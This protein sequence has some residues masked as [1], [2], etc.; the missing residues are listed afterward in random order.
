MGNKREKPPLPPIIER[1]LV[2]LASVRGMAVR[3]LE[4]YRLDLGRFAGYCQN[5]GILAEEATRQEVRCFM[6]DISAEDKA[7]VTVNRSLAS[8]RGFYR[9]LVRFGYR[10]DNPTE[11]I[12]SLKTPKI[13]PVFLWVEEMAAFAA[14][15]DQAQILWPV[16]DKAL[17]LTLYSGG[18]RISEAASMKMGRLAADLSG[19]RIIG[20]GDKERYVFFSGEAVQ[21]LKA[22]L[23]VRE[24]KLPQENLNDWLFLN[25]KGGGLSVSGVR[26][27]IY[28]YALRSGLQKRLHPHALRHSFAAHLVNAGCD[29]RVVQALLGHESIATTQRYTHVNMERLKAVYAQAH[30]HGRK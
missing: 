14:L 5:R 8:L 13:L 23:P 20:K 17:L 24:E 16:R 9:W 2:Y 11:L 7:V 1:Y 18:L 4:A 22:Y 12:S 26:W 19:A 29:V 6:V 15:P 30:P 28:Q 3:T 10:K 21:A 25:Q 27:I